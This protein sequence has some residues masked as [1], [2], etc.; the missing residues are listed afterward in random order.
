MSVDGASVDEETGRLNWSLTVQ[1]KT[2]AVKRLA[3]SVTYPKDQIYYEVLT[4]TGNG[5]KTC[6]EC[7]DFAEGMFCPNCGHKLE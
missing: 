7:G 2:T 6:P 5:L 3:Y 1:G 4:E